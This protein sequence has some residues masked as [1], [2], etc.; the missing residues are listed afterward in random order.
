MMFRKFNNWFDN[1]K[2]PRRTLYFFGWSFTMII[3]V[4]ISIPFI[5]FLGGVMFIATTVVGISRF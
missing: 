3:L 2:E 5:V 4:S 1:L